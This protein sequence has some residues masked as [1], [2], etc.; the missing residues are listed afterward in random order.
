MREIK[1][2]GIIQDEEGSAIPYVCVR[3]LRKVQH[4][5]HTVYKDVAKCWSDEGG[6]YAFQVSRERECVYKVVVIWS[7]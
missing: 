6:R 1:I 7:L 2:W 4:N 3:L 5:R